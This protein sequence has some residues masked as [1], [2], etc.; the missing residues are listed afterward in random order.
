MHPAAAAVPPRTSTLLSA[1]A[2]VVV[3]RAKKIVVV[4]VKTFGTWKTDRENEDNTASAHAR[5]KRRHEGIPWLWSLNRFS[6]PRVLVTGPPGRGPPQSCTECVDDDTPYRTVLIELGLSICL[7]QSR[8]AWASRT[9]R[10]TTDQWSVAIA[11][12]TSS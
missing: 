8:G 3:L 9:R 11:D 7:Q 6:L 12:S 2:Y 10:W 1:A 5:W 4:V